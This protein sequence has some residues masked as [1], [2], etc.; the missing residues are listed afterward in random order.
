MLLKGQAAGHP[1]QVWHL[2][3]GAGPQTALQEVSVVEGPAVEGAYVGENPLS[4]SSL[5][6][7]KGYHLF[8]FVFFCGLF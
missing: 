8:V 4:S 7:E 2:L 3:G 6:I 1:G 5:R